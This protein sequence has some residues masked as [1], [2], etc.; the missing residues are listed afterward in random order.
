MGYKTTFAIAMVCGATILYTCTPASVYGWFS[1][2]PLL[3]PLV[4]MM[5][6]IFIVAPI[7]AFVTRRHYIDFC[8]DPCYQ[9]T[10]AAEEAGETTLL[11]TVV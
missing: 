7:G 10:G 11:L 8:G 5:G 2:L 3:I 4:L 6:Y 9:T 1:L